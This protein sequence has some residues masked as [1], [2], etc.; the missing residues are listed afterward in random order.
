MQVADSFLKKAQTQIGILV[1][2][3][4]LGEAEVD[5]PDGWTNADACTAREDGVVPHA[6][7]LGVSFGGTR[8]DAYK[9]AM[10]GGH[11]VAIGV[12]LVSL[13]VAALQA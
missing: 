1:D 11:V 8:G 10:V 4:G 7:D 6:V 2:S 13:R 12:V 5:D 3:L 9:F